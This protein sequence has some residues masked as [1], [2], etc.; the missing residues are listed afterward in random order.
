MPSAFFWTICLAHLLGDYPLQT[1]RMAVAKRTWPGLTLHVAI[2][3]FVLLVLVGSAAAVL[4]P[5]LLALAG[6]H[7]AIDAF[8]NRM[9]LLRPQAAVRLYVFDQGLH[10]LSLIGVA[11]WAG[12]AGALV[13][14]ARAYLLPESWA[15]VGCGLVFVTFMWGI[16]ERIFFHKRTGFVAEVAPQKWPRMA[17]RALVYGMIVLA[18]LAMLPSTSLVVAATV[19]PYVA[20]VYRRQA[21]MS[22]VVTPV[23][24][25]GAVLMLL[26]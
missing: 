21:L 17:V 16:S 2:H 20:G 13:G 4:W 14:L 15:I 8:K 1:D 5:Y 9:S 6:V 19:L 25:A 24:T 12:S 18:G 7:F 26:R 23:L 10:L 11:L 3:L 22:D